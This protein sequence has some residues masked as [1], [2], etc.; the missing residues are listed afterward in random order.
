VRWSRGGLTFWAVSDI[1]L[2]ELEQF[3][4]AFVARTP[5]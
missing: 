5:G 3:R 4:A 2:T 1:D